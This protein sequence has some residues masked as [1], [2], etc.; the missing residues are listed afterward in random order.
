[1]KRISDK[2]YDA[3]QHDSRRLKQQEYELEKSREMLQQ[4]ADSL[5][6][7]TVRLQ[8]AE[9]SNQQL[10]KAHA[11]AVKTVQVFIADHARDTETIAQLTRL[12]TQITAAG[13]EMSAELKR[14]RA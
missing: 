13:N 12:L 5:S 6:K 10:S 1:M 9:A 8:N 2:F 11:D 14:L 3:M 7:V 4:Y